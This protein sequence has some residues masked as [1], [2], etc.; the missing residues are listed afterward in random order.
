MS[1]TDLDIAKLKVR[2]SYKHT[3]TFYS[4][5]GSASHKRIYAGSSDYS[6]YVFDP[7]AEKF[8]PIA[9]WERH[10]NYVSALAYIPSGDRDYVVSGSYDRQLVWWS[11]DTGEP[12]RSV[13]AHNGWIRDLAVIPG[14]AGFVS[15]GDDMVVKFWNPTSGELMRSLEGHARRTPQGH[16]TAL[17]VVIASPDG[18]YVASGDRVGEVRVWE[19]ETG[20]LA[21]SFQV[22][23]LYTYDPRQR[24][25]SIGGIR[26]LAFSSDGKRLAVG[27]IGQIGNV[28][29][30]AGPAH[31]EIWDWQAPRLLLAAEAEGHKAIMHQLRFHPTEPLLVGVG[32]G[33]D[34]GLLAFWNTNVAAL[35]YSGQSPGTADAS[36]PAS[37]AHRVKNDLFMHRFCFDRSGSQLF[38]AGHGRLDAWHT[39]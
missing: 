3:G 27:G 22:P 19:V 25:R 28:D 24:K 20:K 26:S 16:V 14:G 17:Y 10:D 39:G 29:G 38:I 23:I 35:T 18:K 5:C 4:L 7:A 36:K 15:V 13:A 2:T 37:P 12:V 6:I 11:A 31:V 30:L 1:P 8:D 21:Q 34:D 33:S 32:G 9:R